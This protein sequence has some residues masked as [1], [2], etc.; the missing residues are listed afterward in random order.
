MTAPPRD[1]QWAEHTVHPLTLPH[2]RSFC[3]LSAACDEMLY[4]TLVL[5]GTPVSKFA[6]I[7]PAFVAATQS[8]LREVCRSFLRRN[9]D[10][11]C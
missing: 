7:L 8:R 3:R 1:V 5:L 9:N 11:G 4:I 10:Q 2:M 6:E